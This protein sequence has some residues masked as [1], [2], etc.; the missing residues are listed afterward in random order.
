ML[1]ILNQAIQSPFILQK[2][3]LRHII[4]FDYL[5]FDKFICY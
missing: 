4:F 3:D 1:R 5:M 2:S